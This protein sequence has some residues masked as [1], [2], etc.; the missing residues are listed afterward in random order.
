MPQSRPSVD[1]EAWFASCFIE[2]Y[3]AIYDDKSTGAYTCGRMDFTDFAHMVAAMVDGHDDCRRD[4][5]KIAGEFLRESILAD[6][7][8]VDAILNSV[9][10]GDVVKRFKK[11][12]HYSC[13]WEDEECDECHKKQLENELIINSIKKE[14]NDKKQLNQ[15]KM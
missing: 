9:K 15:N 8:L 7:A 2:R 10:W 13:N 4:C 11:D 6:D 5:M 14:V 3:D 1:L 12:T